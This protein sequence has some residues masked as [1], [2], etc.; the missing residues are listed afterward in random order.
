MHARVEEL[1]PGVRVLPTRDPVRRHARGLSA[2]GDAMTCHQCTTPLT[3]AVI[4]ESPHEVLCGLC[5]S[6]LPDDLIGQEQRDGRLYVRCHVLKGRR[7][8]A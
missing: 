7:V 2:V 3:Y 8:A 5:A 6:R 4:L 1:V